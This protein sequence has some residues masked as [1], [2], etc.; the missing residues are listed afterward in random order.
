MKQARTIVRYEDRIKVIYNE[1]VKL[2]IAHIRTYKH[3]CV[4]RRQRRR[5]CRGRDPQY[6]TCRGRPVL[7]TPNILTLVFYFFPSVELLN[8]A[9]RCLFFHLQCSRLL[10]RST[11]CKSLYFGT[12]QRNGK[13]I[14]FFGKGHSTAPPQTHPFAVYGASIL[15]SSALDLRPPMFEWR[16][17]HWLCVC[18]LDTTMSPTTRSSAIAEG[19]RDAP[20]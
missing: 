10:A 8:T 11:K 14:N 17:R 4:H 19:P 16:W 13:L 6:L 5:G 12:H 2:Q 9:S 15:E 18:L 3:G 7:T 1:N 20:C